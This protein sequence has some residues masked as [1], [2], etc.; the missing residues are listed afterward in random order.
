[1]RMP[2]FRRT[3]RGLLLIAVPL[4]SS[5]LLAACSEPASILDTAGPVANSE[6]FLFW[7]IL[8]IATLVF[9]CVEGALVYSIVRFR[10]RPGTPNPKQNH[11]NLKIE[12][13]WTIIPTIFLLVILVFT[14]RGL[15]QV[16]PESEPADAHKVSVTAVGHQW[17][18]E[19]HYNDYN[20]TTADTLHVPVGTVIHVNLFSNNVIHSFWVPQLTGKTDLIPGHNNQKWFKADQPGTYEGI[21]AEYCG[22]QHGNMR[23][24]VQVDSA[25]TFQT[26]ITTQNQHA[27]TPAAGS[28]AAQGLETFKGAGACSGC[29]G[30]MGVNATSYVDTAA[31]CDDSKPQNEKNNEC[32][33]GPNLTHFGSRGLIAGGVLENNTDK[34]N[35]SSYSSFNDLLA[36][37][38][39]AKWLHD[40]QAVKPGNDMVINLTNQ[41]VEQLVAYLET[42][43]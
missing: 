7:V 37:C 28:L 21:C 43:K 33:L 27:V 20:I 42:L 18:W 40:P 39:L 36:N 6:S 22:A 15:F 1:M 13:I 41:Q 24:T 31:V 4:L 14:I 34:C 17:W 26:W 38:N 2:V 25:D 12:L 19:F 29:H 3:K 16:A 11:G 30:I 8:A 9:L 10:D 35:V 5:M 23:F 32:L